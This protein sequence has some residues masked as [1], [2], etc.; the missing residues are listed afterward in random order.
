MQGGWPKRRARGAAKDQ[1]VEPANTDR[2]LI[3]DERAQGKREHGGVN[4]HS[5]QF[6]VSS[7]N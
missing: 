2:G 7:A 4:V 3:G 5:E 6:T 1:H